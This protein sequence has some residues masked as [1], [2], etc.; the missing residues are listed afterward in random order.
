MHCHTSFGLN[1]T[2]ACTNLAFFQQEVGGL[3]VAPERCLRA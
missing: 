2:P 1:L 3:D